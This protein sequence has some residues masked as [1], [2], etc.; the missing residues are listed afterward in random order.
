MHTKEIV[1]NRLAQVDDRIS[2]LESR[3]MVLIEV[4]GELESIIEAADAPRG[5]KKE[6]ADESPRD[7]TI[8]AAHRRREEYLS[9]TRTTKQ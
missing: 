3:L 5:A 4:K 7:D 6:S 8:E 1:K 9:K 2:E